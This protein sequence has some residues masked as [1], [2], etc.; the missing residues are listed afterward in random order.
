MKKEVHFFRVF[1][2]LTVV[3]SVLIVISLC[4]GEYNITFRELFNSLLGKQGY[5]RTGLVIY[6]FRLPRIILSF[7][8][9][10]SL[11]C[12]G[13][14]L[15]VLTHNPLADSGLLGINAGAS[16]GTVAYLFVL[17]NGYELTN[18]FLVS[19]MPFFGVF[20]GLLA[21]GLIF[22]LSFYKGQ[23]DLGKMILNGM[24]ISLG[25]SSLTMYLSLKLQP[26]AYEMAVVWISG[27]IYRANWTMIKGIILWMVL[28]LPLVYTKR[29]ILDVLSLSDDLARN[30]GVNIKKERFIIILYATILVCASVS[31][32]GSI[33]FIGIIAPHIARNLVPH[34]AK[35]ILPISILLGGT[36]V[37]LCDF[38]SKN[39]FAPIELPLS[40]LTGIIGG[41]IYFYLMAKDRKG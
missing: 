10:A 6:E 1:L 33:S 20:G 30:L 36:L 17:N 4:F 18:I 27:S 16:F 26:D 41:I 28:I 40:V 24:G 35:Y 15:Q 13:Y 23:I 25:F 2:V 29:H 31:V 7:L 5:E 12:V 9:G 32:A 8:V 34:R 14:L 37:I 21:V 19:L 22:S 39:L 3:L 38:I 11:G